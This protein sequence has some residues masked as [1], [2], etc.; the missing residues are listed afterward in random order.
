MG[1]VCKRRKISGG[2]AIIE[3]WIGGRGSEGKSF[4]YYYP[5]EMHWKQVWVTNGGVE[6]KPH[7]KTL[8]NGGTRFQGVVIA[9]IGTEYLDRTTLNTLE[10]G[11]VEQVI[12]I[13]S[14]DE[15]R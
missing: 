11:N 4:F 9:N 14:D 2:C 15:E 13:S 3:S 7:V 10:N 5:N 12:A 1:C 8:E 6:E